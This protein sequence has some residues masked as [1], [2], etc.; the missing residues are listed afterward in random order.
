MAEAKR[1]VLAILAAGRIT[2]HIS[3]ELPLVRAGKVVLTTGR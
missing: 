1:R 3:H 2:P